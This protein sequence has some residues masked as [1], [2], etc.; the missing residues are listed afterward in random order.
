MQ[1]SHILNFRQAVSLQSTRISKKTTKK[2]LSEQ[3]P[4]DSSSTQ[5]DG[6]ALP[7]DIDISEKPEE[8]LLK[9]VS[10]LK[11]KIPSFK[12]QVLNNSLSDEAK[13]DRE[14]VQLEQKEGENA[15]D[16]QEEEEEEE[17]S[18]LEPE[19]LEED[20]E[21][22]EIG[23]DAGD[24]IGDLNQGT[25]EIGPDLEKENDKVKLFIGGVLHNREDISNIAYR[26]F[27]YS[28]C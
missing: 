26:Y 2:Q 20:D 23:E 6:D 3:E 4:G 21:E 11:E 24:E 22:N 25:Q 13:L 12:V 9:L 28:T 27:L 1:K 15:E 8:A 19:E 14:V 16:E 5:K 18:E 17:N 10:S 7:Q